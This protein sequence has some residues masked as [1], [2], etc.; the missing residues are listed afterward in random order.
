MLFLVLNQL[1]Q[2]KSLILLFKLKNIRLPVKYFNN[3]GINGVDPSSLYKSSVHNAAVNS[4][5]IK[6]ALNSYFHVL[7]IILIGISI[8]SLILSVIMPKNGASLLKSI[9]LN[10]QTTKIY[11]YFTYT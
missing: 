4:E 2:L 1:C 11:K 7:F 3:L 10:I 5:Q 6:L 8:L 9:L